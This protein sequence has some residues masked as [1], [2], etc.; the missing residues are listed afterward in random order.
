MNIELTTPRLLIR[1]A[2]EK[3]V[4]GF[5]E[6]D[7]NPEV[8]RFLGNQPAQT[9]EECLEM[10]R[11]IQDQY[12]DNGTGRLSVIERETQ[13]F[14]GWAGLKLITDTVNGHRQYLDLGYRFVESSWGKGY[15]TEAATAILDWAFS[16][17]NTATIYAITHSENKASDRILRKLGFVYT[18]RF[19]HSGVPHRWYVITRSDWLKP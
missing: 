4:D 5:F 12:R 15:A 3:D 6:L 16:T 2:T 11:F 14:I 1:P 19:E 9:R 13:K 10:I 17:G 7:H 8:H 18:N